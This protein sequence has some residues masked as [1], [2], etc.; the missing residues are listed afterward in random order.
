MYQL[1]VISPQVY[2]SLQ[3]DVGNHPQA[4]KFMVWLAHKRHLV[5]HLSLSSQAPDTPDAM[6]HQVQLDAAFVGAA[7]HPGLVNLELVLSSPVALGGWAA[8]LCGLGFLAINCPS[9]GISASL[10]QVRSLSQ[11]LCHSD[12][13]LPCRGLPCAC[14]FTPL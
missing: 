3:A 13:L 6:R 5:R 11:I 7:C 12:G 2:A 14:V 1:T 9:I 4:E 8:A 10:S